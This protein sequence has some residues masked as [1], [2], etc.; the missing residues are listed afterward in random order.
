MAYGSA[1]SAAEDAPGTR[2]ARGAFFTPPE[3]ARFVARWAIRFP[4]DR[5]LEPACGEAEFLVAASDRLRSLGCKS[6]VA[7]R[8]VVGCEV[9]EASAEKAVG[10]LGALG[11]SANIVVSDFLRLAPDPS[12]DV[13][14][15]QSALCA[16]SVAVVRSERCHR[17]HR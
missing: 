16:V 1:L 6:A 12:F 9:H 7:E 2:K 5:V 8:N 14:I 3:L 4:G 15:G 11:C 17:S 10:R 13:V